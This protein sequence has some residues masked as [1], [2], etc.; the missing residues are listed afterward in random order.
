MKNKISDDPKLLGILGGMGPAATIDFMEKLI[1]V[2]G[3]KK[4]QDQIP[5]V[6]Y[7]NTQIPDRNEAFLRGGESPVSELLKSPGYWKR[8]DA[9]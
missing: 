8:L 4:D 2:T 7:N 1:K 6:V 5:A 9:I 3:A